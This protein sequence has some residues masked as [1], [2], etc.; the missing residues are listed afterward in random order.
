MMYLNYFRGY[1]DSEPKTTTLEEVV[2]LI[3][4]DA[5]V[6]DLTE[7]HRYY[8]SMGDDKSARQCKR[9]LPCFAVAVR[10]E[11]GKQQCHIV[12][13]TGLSIVDIDHVAPDDLARV[14]A[15]IKRDPHTL[16]AYT[17]VSGHGVRVL[18]RW[19][20]PSMGRTQ[21]TQETIHTNI[22]EVLPIEGELSE[23]LRGSLYKESF[24]AINDYYR[25][26]T[27][28]N[29]DL[30]CKNVTRLSGIAHD[31]A[32]YYNP[33][34]EAFVIEPEQRRPVGRPCRGVTPTKVEAAIAEEL[35][36]RG[37]H[38][39]AGSHNRYIAQACYLMNRYGVPEADCTDWALT[40]FAD[41]QAA[42]NDV[43]G[44]VGS[45]YR[46][47]EEHATLRPPREQ[48]ERYASVKEIQDYLTEKAVRIRHNLVSRKW[49]IKSC[50]AAVNRDCVAGE[51]L[52]VKGYEATLTSGTA[53]INQA[54]PINHVE[55]ILTAQSVLTSSEATIN[56]TEAAWTD[57]T[58]RHVNSIYRAFSL[59]TGRRL[60][61]SD[62]YII[63]ESDFY[64]T[65]HPFREYLEA[66]PQWDGYD[67]IDELA[68]R[69]HVV[70]CEQKMHNRYFK[71]WFVAMVAA[72]IADG[73]TNHEILT[74]I[75]SQGIYKSTFM[76]LLLPPALRA[77][78]SARNFAHRMNKDD[79]LEL[80]EMGLIALEELDHMKP[81][82][83][84]QLKAI[85]TDPTVNERAAYAHFRERREH[86]ASFCGTGNNARFLT[87]LTGNRRWLPFM[88]DS[89][90]SPYEHP[91][92]YE[93]LY[94]QAYAL[95]REGFPYWF[96][97]EENAELEQHNRHFEEP[98][99]ELELI[100]TYFRMPHE[101]E[102]GEFY[103]ATRIIETINYSVKT[104]LQPRN[105]AIWM[106]K[107]GYTQRRRD[108]IRGWNVIVLNCTEI[109]LKQ[110]ENAR[111]STP[112]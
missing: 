42:G 62:L 25:R 28:H 104:P 79:R 67:Y 20:P 39:E 94:A 4:D 27:G 45:C 41:Y 34:A 33:E 70:G 69:V 53:T 6:R 110:Q 52:K 84:N 29:T 109:K 88:V 92:P 103:T 54:K 112:E 36:R 91:F 90:D 66:L 105:I 14:L 8:L 64:P 31:P 21:S 101:H 48:K 10:F 18:A 49:E 50:E 24:L 32:V 30:Q 83:L 47:T 13:Y 57:L 65:Y 3:A 111:M 11:G 19:E 22:P 93:G 1:T 85:T 35:E 46:Q 37:V 80:T 74:Y 44:I 7:K 55:D 9:L 99:M 77:Y 82:E 23:G 78:F 59:D 97:H 2:R 63:I 95:W 51:G 107:L 16:L 72:W 5:S 108:N 58:D 56:R 106:N 40:R 15:V 43:A 73:V 71:K 100:Q 89:I 76:R 87:D 86:I 38:Y 60:R 96:S 75:G 12:D 26:I 102:I 68:S 81:Y 17:T 61:I 98:N